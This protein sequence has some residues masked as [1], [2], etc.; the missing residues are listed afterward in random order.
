LE[1]DVPVRHRVFLTGGLLVVAGLALFASPFASSDPDGLERVATDKGFAEKA[2]EHALG[3]SPV[4]D[5]SV[6]GIEDD[7]IGTGLSGLAGVLIT[8]AVGS[9]LFGQLRKRGGERERKR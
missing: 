8:F 5:Y 9:A 3:D 2:K 4:A 7:R 6:E 1:P